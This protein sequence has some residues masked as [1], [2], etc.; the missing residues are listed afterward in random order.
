MSPWIGIIFRMQSHFNPTITPPKNRKDRGDDK[1]CISSRRGLFSLLRH[2]KQKDAD[3]K[4]KQYDE[5][6]EER[7]RSHAPAVIK[8]K[9]PEAPREENDKA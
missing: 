1:D 5:Q 2:P 7:G 6:G 4:R 8:H 9:E 3:T